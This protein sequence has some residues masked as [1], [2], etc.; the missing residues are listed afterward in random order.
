M[1]SQINNISEATASLGFLKNTDTGLWRLQ[2]FLDVLVYTALAWNRRI[3]LFQIN[4]VMSFLG[5]FDKP[6]C[7]SLSSLNVIIRRMMRFSEND[8]DLGPCIQDV[9]TREHAH[10]LYPK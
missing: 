1:L 5:Q 3:E 10:S 8:F 9:N 4:D 6:A 7:Y 2:D